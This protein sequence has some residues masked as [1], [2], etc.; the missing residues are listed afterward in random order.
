MVTKRDRGDEVTHFTT[1]IYTNCGKMIY[2]FFLYKGLTCSFFFLLT[3]TN[4]ASI[5]HYFYVVVP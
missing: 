2:K 1:V 4:T 3:L 5:F